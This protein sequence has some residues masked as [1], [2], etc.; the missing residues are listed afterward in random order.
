M[1]EDYI[2]RKHVDLFIVY[3]ALVLVVRA[4]EIE[5]F[6]FNL[7]GFGCITLFSR[8]FVNCNLAFNGNVS[9]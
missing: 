1:D 2:F 4:P 5:S 8:L 7:F 6:V 3:R 9:R